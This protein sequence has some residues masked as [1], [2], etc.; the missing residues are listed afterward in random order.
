MTVLVILYW[1]MAIVVATLAFRL[2]EDMR[3]KNASAFIR[4]GIAALIGL[5]WP[6]VLLGLFLVALDGDGDS[7]EDD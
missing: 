4:A 2:L 1:V 7:L 5:L 3:N 6:P